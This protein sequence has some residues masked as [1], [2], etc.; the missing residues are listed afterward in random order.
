MRFGIFW[1]PL[2]FELAKHKYIIDAAFRLHNFIVDF[3]ER[4]KCTVS[5]MDFFTAD[6]LKFLTANLFELVG[7]YGNG[8]DG[9]GINEGDSHL[10]R[11]VNEGK[12]LRDALRDEFKKKGLTRR[13]NTKYLEP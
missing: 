12:V 1:T 5:D 4:N 6:C 7:T 9:E 10:G 8:I 2:Q 3:R 13:S 11:T